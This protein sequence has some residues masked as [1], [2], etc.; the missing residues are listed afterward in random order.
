MSALECGVCEGRYEEP[1]LLACGHTLCVHCVEQ[2][3]VIDTTNSEALYERLNPSL[4][5][6]CPQCGVESNR[7]QVTTDY[8]TVSALEGEAWSQCV[9]QGSVSCGVCEGE[10]VIDQYCTTCQSFLCSHCT[11]A[12]RRMTTFRK[13]TL[14]PPDL[15][16]LTFSPKPKDMFCSNHPNVVV[17]MYCF[18]CDE[19][20]CNECMCAV[21]RGRVQGPSPHASHEVHT[22]TDKSLTRLTNKVE[23]LVARAKQ[24]Q[25][26]LNQDMCVLKLQEEGVKVHP[27]KLTK[28]VNETV[29][30]WIAAIE[31]TRARALREISEDHQATLSQYR[32]E[33]AVIAGRVSGIEAGLR[34]TDRVM[35]CTGQ[36]STKYSMLAQAQRLLAAPV[37]DT[38]SSD[39]PT[40]CLFYRVKTPRR[41][42]SCLSLLVSC[43]QS[44]SIGR[45]SRVELGRES[46]VQ[47]CFKHRPSDP[48]LLRLA[49]LGRS[50]RYMPLSS[51]TRKESC[52]WEVVF[53][54]RCIGRYQVEAQVFGK[55]LAASQSFC[56]SPLSQLTVGDK[57]CVS[58]DAPSE[59]LL[60]RPANCEVGKIKSI[61]YSSSGSGRTINYCFEISW[62]TI[63]TQFKFSYLRNSYNPFPL[64]LV[65]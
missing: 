63:D 55:W 46:S 33:K 49:Y 20:I 59:L 1:R 41:E 45:I 5:I 12:H 28:A 7:E 58:I 47:V 29:D 51:C 10:G 27:N 21:V 44:L 4:V 61:Q 13:H 48:P 23:C 18:C 36:S 50:K 31:T 38:S 19:L 34:Y 3:S 11:T 56:T 15:S 54:P 53:T 2:L 37:K 8:V 64:E 32:E 60:S 17:N 9:E 40:S 16:S 22:I 35:Q 26:S 25:E 52:V 62:D 24:L 43:E 30:S 6:Q 14:S 42:S 57:V 39:T 65:L